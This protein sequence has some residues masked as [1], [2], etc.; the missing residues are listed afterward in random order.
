MRYLVTGGTGF[1]GRA[2]CV[3]LLRGGHQVVVL[4]R[5]VA[6][7]R[8]WLPA[9]AEAVEEL[10][11]LDG[12]DAVVNLAGE[13]VVG[14]RWS[15]ARK[16]ALLGSRIG[17][18]A[19][20]L[21]WIERLP[22]RP[23]V[24]VSGS[25]IGYYGAHGDEA[26]DE[27]A[28]AGGDFAARLCVAWEAAALEAAALG[29]RV[30]LVRIGVV[31]GRG[32]GALAGMIAP[33]RLGLGGPMGDGRQ[34][35]SWVHRADLVSLLCRLAEDPATSGVYNGTAPQPVTNGVFSR[36]LGRALGRPAF[37]VTPAFVLRLLFGEMA[38]LFLTG[39]NVVPARATAAGF[40]FR[41]PDL[42]SALREVLA[43]A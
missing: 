26:L 34:W 30:C 32:G 23:Q 35:M 39:Q 37:L 24:L 16:Q 19:A 33:F 17:T 6:A 14:G 1:I 40:R 36:S 43:P 10:A 11:A 20:L 42:D 18:T 3:E 31:L 38:E 22:R 27:Q 21:R 9:G 15:V 5:S 7:A 13:S 28:P 41:Y 12:A 8:R 25:A 29:L 4:T 2:L